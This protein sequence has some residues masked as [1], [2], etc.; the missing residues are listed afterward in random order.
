MADYFYDLNYNQYNLFV[1]IVLVLITAVLEWK[2][3]LV[4]CYLNS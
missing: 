2:K 3:D 1:I 4:H